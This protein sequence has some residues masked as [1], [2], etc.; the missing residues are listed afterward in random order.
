[1]AYSSF[2]SGDCSENWYRL[3]VTWPPIRMVGGFCRY[4][5]MPGRLSSFG[6]RSAM[7]FSTSSLRWARGFR[8]TTSCPKFGP[9]SVFEAVPPTVDVNASTLGLRAHDLGDLALILHHLIER[10]ALRRFG[11]HRQLIGVLI[12]E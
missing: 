4:T 7:M 11:D 10:S 1:M 2:L 9:P 8:R 6:R 3:L 5:F 12:R